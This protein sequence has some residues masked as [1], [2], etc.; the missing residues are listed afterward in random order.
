VHNDPV[1]D[2]VMVLMLVFALFAF[3]VLFMI[4]RI[5]RLE[6]HAHRKKATEIV[7][8]LKANTFE[9]QR[10]AAAQ[11]SIDEATRIREAARERHL[12][13]QRRVDDANRRVRE[14]RAAMNMDFANV[15]GDFARACASCGGG[16]TP[17]PPSRGSPPR[18]TTGPG[19][20]SRRSWSGSLI[21]APT[22]AVGRRSSG[23]R[24]SESLGI[25]S[26][27]M[28]MNMDDDEKPPKDDDEGPIPYAK[29]TELV[30]G[31]ASNPLVTIAKDGT[32]TYGLNYTPDEA[33]RAFWEMM[34]KRRHDYEERLVFF[35]HVEQL[36][37]KLGE[38][39][40]RTEALRNKAAAPDATPH[41]DFQAQRA[42]DQLGLYADEMFKFARGMALRDRAN[43]QEPAQADIEQP[44]P[45]GPKR[46]L[47]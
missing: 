11:R 9:Q 45:Q 8:S 33:A 12:E 3:G 41:D 4:Q 5:N 28:R 32:L 14:S 1:R 6:R 15:S 10:Q 43:R 46:V 38:Q 34:A 29:P 40:L 2:A 24:D 47:H 27:R 31:T 18:S 16:T 44:V 30:V 22:A 20:R 26:S 39:D 37:A 19:A 35:A 7:K 21:D 25:R 36:L 13:A 23:L 42:I 17:S